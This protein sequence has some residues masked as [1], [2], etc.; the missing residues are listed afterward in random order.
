M[1]KLTSE[2]CIPSSHNMAEAHS[3]VTLKN[4]ATQNTSFVTQNPERSIEHFSCQYL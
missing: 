3:P 2:R 1:I 4:F